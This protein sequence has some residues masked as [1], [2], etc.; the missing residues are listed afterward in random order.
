MSSLTQAEAASEE[1]RR[2][3]VA[4][5]IKAASDDED[6]ADD[7]DDDD[8]EDDFMRAESQSA[9]DSDEDEANDDDEDMDEDGV[10]T[11]EDGDEEGEED[12]DDEDDDDEEDLAEEDEEEDE[13]QDE[14]DLEV[15]DDDFLDD[16]LDVNFQLG[17]AEDFFRQLLE[18]STL[19][20]SHPGPST[21]TDLTTDWNTLLGDYHQ[22]QQAQQSYQAPVQ[23]PYPTMSVQTPSAPPP[24]PNP[25]YSNQPAH[26]STSYSQTPGPSMHNLLPAPSIPSQPLAPSQQVDT[27]AFYKYAIQVLTHIL[28]TGTEVSTHFSH[29]QH[30][31]PTVTPQIQVP[32]Q[33]ASGI[34]DLQPIIAAITSRLTG[35]S[36]T[37]PVGEQEMVT[38][39]QSLMH[40]VADG[41]SSHN[42]GQAASPITQNARQASDTPQIAPIVDVSQS[43]RSAGPAQLP[44]SQASPRQPPAAALQ[45]LRSQTS[46]E[47][48]R[49]ETRAVTRQTELVAHVNQGK[50]AKDSAS[51]TSS[52]SPSVSPTAVSETR[53]EETHPAAPEPTSTTASSTAKGKAKSSTTTGRRKSVRKSKYTAAERQQRKRDRNR[54]SAQRSRARKKDETDR[55]RAQL[56]AAGIDPGQRGESTYVRGRRLPTETPTA[57]PLPPPSAPTPIPMAS[58]TKAASSA[59]KGTTTHFSTATTPAGAKVVEKWFVVGAELEPLSPSSLADQSTAVATREMQLRAL[60]AEVKRL[61]GANDQMKVE[62]EGLRKENAELKGARKLFELS[63]GGGS[64][65]TGSNNS[66][67]PTSNG[68]GGVGGG[69]L[70]AIGSGSLLYNNSGS[71]RIRPARR[72]AVSA[73]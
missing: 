27:D 50:L 12:D 9:T 49:R 20:P 51:P 2:L 44:D 8:D 26:V 61:K 22:S 62:M 15:D 31:Q 52:A 16:T 10:V 1:A 5:W 65:S 41:S 46:P 55:Y 39:L 45:L 34:T 14:D 35:T 72:A 64:G 17:D 13:D 60:M 57:L 63:G 28:G 19:D 24:A 21:T 4:N 33:P 6:E 7:F 36:V 30:G 73:R 42:G 69:S 53:P 43:S 29:R 40:Q 32:Q 38:L 59:P 47:E 56:L 68:N 23:S 70:L 58:T 71:A 48:T 54:L 25:Y 18:S 3:K 66:P 11:N 37:G 67:G